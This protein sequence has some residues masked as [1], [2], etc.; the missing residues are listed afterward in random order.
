MFSPETEEEWF[1]WE[2]KKAESRS[3]RTRKSQN[4]N[5][6]A[7]AEGPSKTPLRDKV[8]VWQAGVKDD[9]PQNPTKLSQRH[10]TSPKRARS[11]TTTLGFPV[12]KRATL[13]KDGKGKRP[14]ASFSQPISVSKLSQRE[15]ESIRI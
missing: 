7:S 8:I 10:P 11:E 13:L 14:A 4:V 9:S 12:V 15:G 2:R 5:L 3:G 6:T 1:E